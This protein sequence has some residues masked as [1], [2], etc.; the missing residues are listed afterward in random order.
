[1]IEDNRVPARRNAL[2]G[3]ALSG[4]FVLVAVALEVV[5]GL[6]ANSPAPAWAERVVPL[7]WRQPARDPLACLGEGQG[8][9]RENSPDDRQGRGN[10]GRAG[11]FP[12][13]RR[14]HGTGDR[15]EER[16]VDRQSGQPSRSRIRW[17]VVGV[18]AGAQDSPPPHGAGEL[19]QSSGLAGARAPSS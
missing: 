12:A 13:G 14:R 15:H 17:V 2:V 6:G 9:T 1:M 7:A 16:L 10:A 19:T 4:G 11:W 5:G 18:V 8:R 3:A